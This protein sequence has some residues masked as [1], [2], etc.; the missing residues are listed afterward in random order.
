MGETCGQKALTILRG[1]KS[2]AGNLTPVKR[3]HY[4]TNQ[5][6]AEHMKLEI[7]EKVLREASQ[8]Y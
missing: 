6:V 3:V 8:V 5:K 2:E 1:D 4:A 7:P